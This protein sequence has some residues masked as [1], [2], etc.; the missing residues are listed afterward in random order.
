[1]VVKNKLTKG[2]ALEKIK[3][4]CSYQERCHSEVKDK[5]Y[6]YGLV[7]KE[8]EETIAEII[9]N[10]YLNEERFAIQFAGGKFRM[11]HWG[12]RKIQYELQQKGVNAFIIKVAL[13]EIEE[14]KYLQIL[15]KLTQIKW[16][17]LSR[18]NKLARRTKTTAYLLQKGYEQKLISQVIGEIK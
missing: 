15:Q 11:K 12:R 8:V 13:K 5:L 18:E 17:I 16:D 4:Y 10:N 9:E 3:H 1:M 7:K 6:S 2:Q 14:K